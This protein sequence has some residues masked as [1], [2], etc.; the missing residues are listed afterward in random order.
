MKQV[1]GVW[2]QPV[3][4]S[5]SGEVADDNLTLVLLNREAG[6]S[7]IQVCVDTG[8]RSSHLGVKPV[9]LDGDGDLDL[10][11]IA[12]RQFSHL[13]AWYNPGIVP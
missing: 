9:D 13:H 3:V 7:W 6:R 2:T 5:F 4:A 10:V 1:N 11:S 8:P 12:W